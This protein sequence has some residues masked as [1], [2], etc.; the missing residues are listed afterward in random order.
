MVYDLSRNEFQFPHPLESAKGNG[1]HLRRRTREM[2]RAYQGTPDIQ[3]VLAATYNLSSDAVHIHNG[4]V[5]ALNN[6]FAGV[7][8]MGND[9]TL[10]LPEPGWDFYERLAAHYEL[11]IARYQYQCSEA[12]FRLDFDDLDRVVSCT[13]NPVVL[14]NSPSNPLGCAET[15]EAI[16]RI[17]TS[18]S[19]RGWLVLDRAYEGFDME[20]D[21]RFRDGQVLEELPRTIVIGSMSKFFGMPG[22]RV[23]FT[24]ATQETQREFKLPYDYLGFNSFSDELAVACLERVMEFEQLAGQMVSNREGLIKLFNSTE[25]FHAYPSSANFILV[26]FQN[27][28][29]PQWLDELGI[30]VRTFDDPPELENCIRLTVPNNEGCEALTRAITN[31]AERSG[32]QYGKRDPLRPGSPE[33]VRIAGL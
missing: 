25:G 7:K 29:V 1:Q 19:G 12:G 10:I 6:I 21:R 27:P 15:F 28:N 18:L 22:A 26:R 8:M 17:A 23:G 33:M 4:A 20:A 13:S 3:S 9:A 32:F 2:L 24:I 16:Q 14:V 11:P 30:K 31:I 5:E